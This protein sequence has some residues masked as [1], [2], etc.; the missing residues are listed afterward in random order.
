[1]VI[2]LPDGSKL[3]FDASVTVL[4]VAEKI[5]KR[6]ARDAVAGR[7][8]GR[9]V[10]LSSTVSDGATV[11]IVT[12][13]SED[14]L[15]VMRHSAAHVM[16]DA[17]QRLFDDV[18]L[19]F[20][21]AED[22]GFYYDFNLPGTISEED[23]ERIEAEMARIVAENLAFEHE[24]IS[25]DEARARLEA[26]GEKLKIEHLD[27]IE[28]DEVTIYTHGTDFWD[29]CAGPHLPS[30]GRIGAV[31]L[32]SVAG[33]YWMGDAEREQLQRVRA[34]AFAG[35]KELAAYLERVEEAKKRD[36]RLLGRELDL[37][38]VNEDIGPGLI[39]WHPKGAM[40]RHIIETFWRDEHL[41]RGYDLVYT[42]HIAS[43]HMYQISGH[44]EKYADMMYAP[45]M[46]DDEAYYIKPM[47]CPAHYRIYQSQM[48]SYRDL[49]VRYAELGT[50]YRYEP[51]GTL[52][53]M[54]RVRGFTQDDAHTFCTPEQLGGEMDLIL[55]LMDFMMRSFGYEYKAYLATRPEK[56]LGTEEDWERATGELRDALERR[57]LDYEVDEGG[58]VFYAPKIDIKLI[59]SLG[60]EWQG[61]THQ[62][63]LQAASRFGIEYVGADNKPH[64]PVIIHRTVLGSMER[65]IGGLVEHYAGAFPVWLAPVQV[66]VAPI[67]DRHSERAAEVAD[68]LRAEGL[69]A[70]LDSRSEKVGFKVREWQLA[71]IPY[72]L[73]IGDREVES[74][75][76][77]VRDRSSGDRG[78]VALD[79]LVSEVLAAD[80]ERK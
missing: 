80:R 26:R 36:H 25:K 44:L 11:Q 9:L 69:R 52:H 57:G 68:R 53:G 19:A 55:E 54:L 70:E 61:P 6:L 72:L 79:D 15:H 20:G 2:A 78:S 16:A 50:V 4:Q 17:V 34:V 30:T 40:V 23:F 63:D 12:A 64:H 7:I 14:G 76:V 29:V 49:P 37:Y 74:G 71:K 46:I 8:D 41:K 77:S 27:R 45:M 22:E 62:V 65:F 42:P 28:G 33:A 58:G 43:E 18:R 39:L 38:S 59:D 10:D 60:R 66:R 1:M 24:V 21:P 35:R 5:G 13:D 47:N 73:I 75:E 48:R 67:A 31:K 3:E 51:S 32:T 56:F